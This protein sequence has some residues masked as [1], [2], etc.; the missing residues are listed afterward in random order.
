MLPWIEYY[1]MMGVELFVVYNKNYHEQYDE[2]DKLL[3]IYLNN[4]LVNKRDWRFG[5]RIID[6]WRGFQVSSLKLANLLP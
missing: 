3:E 1:R 6:P 5:G 2:T 4:G